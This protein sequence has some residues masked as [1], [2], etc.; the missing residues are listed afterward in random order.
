M[1]N[2]EPEYDYSKGHQWGMSIDLTSCT[3]C[4]ACSI[5][6][7]SE[8]NI[9]VV[10][11]QQV[12]NGREMH[13]IRIDNYFSG[14]PDNPEVSTQS[15][16]CVHC[17]LAP[18][19]TVCPVSATTHST[20][21]VNQMAYN[22]CVGTRYCANN[23]P[24]KVRKFNFYN[25]TKDTP[26]VVQM[27]MNPD[28]S[29]RFRGVMEK[30]TYC[31]QRVSDARIK[32]SNEHRELADG[33]IHTACQQ[34]CPA[35]AIIFG[36]INDEQSEVSKAKRRNRDYALLGQIGTSPRTTYLAKIRNQNPKL[37]TNHAG[38]HH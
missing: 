22:R 14:D 8:N 16:A 27:A 33:D 19:E 21:G 5:A 3:G 4:N 13:W 30:C 34:S 6:C 25:F 23:C 37:I 28:V 36:D 38:E 1:Y 24:Y 15:V 11:K 26:E 31:Y 12:L 10:G 9:P 7:Q 18:C 2:P 17:E 29:M 32:A 20:D 35:D